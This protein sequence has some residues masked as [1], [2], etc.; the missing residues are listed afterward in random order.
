[1]TMSAETQ[2]ATPRIHSLGRRGRS[3]QR[4]L[5]RSKEVHPKPSCRRGQILT[6]EYKKGRVLRHRRSSHGVGERQPS[7]PGTYTMNI[8]PQRYRIHADRHSEL[9]A[10]TPDLVIPDA[11]EA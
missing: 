10:I 4:Q 2:E 6:R 8:E 11:L 1:V 3:R 9:A 7:D 5:D